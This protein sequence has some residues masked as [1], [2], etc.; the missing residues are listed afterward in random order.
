MSTAF[1]VADA[2]TYDTVAVQHAGLGHAH[3]KV[4]PMPEQLEQIIVS[5]Q[6]ADR[7][8]GEELRSRSAVKKDDHLPISVNIQPSTVQSTVYT[9]KHRQSTRLVLG[10][11]KLDRT[12]WVCM[13]QIATPEN[14]TKGRKGSGRK[15]IG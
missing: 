8:S 2:F 7:I 5:T 12:K 13:G 6:V 11:F 9:T 1:D 10:Q 14:D 4:R 3:Y 15:S